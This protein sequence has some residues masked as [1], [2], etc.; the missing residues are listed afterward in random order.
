MPRLKQVAAIFA[1]AL[2]GP[3]LSQTGVK[4][5]FNSHLIPKTDSYQHSFRPYNTVSYDQR[6]GPV[7][8]N[9]A[10]PPRTTKAA[11]AMDPVLERLK[12]KL[13]LQIG[14]YTQA[15]T[16]QGPG[17]HQQKPGSY[18]QNQA[19]AAQQQHSAGADLEAKIL[20]LNNNFRNLKTSVEAEKKS[21]ADQMAVVRSSLK[22]MS[23]SLLK[24]YN[25]QKVM[26]GYLKKLLTQYESMRIA[27]NRLAIRLDQMERAL[28]LREIERV[29][30]NEPNPEAEADSHA[31]PDGSRRDDSDPR[32][33]EEEDHSDHDHVHVISVDDSNGQINGADLP[34]P[35]PSS[36]SLESNTV[37]TENEN[38]EDVSIR[39]NADNRRPKPALPRSRQ[40]NSRFYPRSNS[41]AKPPIAVNYGNV[42]YG[43]AY[44]LLS[45]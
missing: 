32:P 29:P 19:P 23:G 35:D 6:I 18:Y 45:N 7:L 42:D 24:T 2:L 5:V 14:A 1:A 43:M 10:G 39:Q 41:N 8:P 40:S 9:Q 38:R 34:A 12:Q 37:W 27:K 28:S 31:S 11:S 16:P 15:A 13:K 21:T 25:N 26:H 4:P 20:M 17:N 44:D 30:G 3:A 22:K 36:N 33:E